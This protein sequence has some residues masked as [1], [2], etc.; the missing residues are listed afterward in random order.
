MTTPTAMKPADPLALL[1][2][3]A[4]WRAAGARPGGPAG[5]AHHPLPAGQRRSLTRRRIQ[6]R[7]AIPAAEILGVFLAA[8]ATLPLGAVLGRALLLACKGLAYGVSMSSFRGGP[9]SPAMF[10]GAV[11]GAAMS[12]LPGRRGR[13]P[14]G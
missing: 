7:G 14:A 10:L 5:R 6:A 1:R 9:T 4:M 12:H 13:A 11:A 8:L 2:T 3:G